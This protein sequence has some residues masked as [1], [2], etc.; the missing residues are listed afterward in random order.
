MRSLGIVCLAVAG[1]DATARGSTQPAAAGLPGLSSKWLHGSD[2]VVYVGMTW[3][4]DVKAGATRGSDQP[5]FF[6]PR[7]S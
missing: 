2:F 6:G 4:I 1:A 3:G 5:G 7:L